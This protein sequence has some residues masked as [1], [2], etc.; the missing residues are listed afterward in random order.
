[1]KLVT[2]IVRTTSLQHVVQHLGKIGVK[3]LTI[4]QIKGLGEE[5]RL[6]NP[7]SIHDKIEIFVPDEKSDEVTQIILEH[8]A[9]GLAGDGLVAVSPVDFAIK[10]R[11][12]EPLT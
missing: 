7:Y 5:L 10:I 2:A 9:M 3:G 8:A 1:M 6:N 4:S 11:N 12:R